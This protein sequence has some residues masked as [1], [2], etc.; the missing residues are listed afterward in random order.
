MMQYECFLAEITCVSLVFGSSTIK[1]LELYNYPIT[2][3]LSFFAYNCVL[4]ILCWGIHLYEGDGDKIQSALA[5]WTGQTTVPNVFIG[6]KHIG[7]C[8]GKNSL[9]I[10]L[11]NAYCL[12]RVYFSQLFSS[13]IPICIVAAV[14]EKHRRG[15][16]IPLLTEAGAIASNSAQL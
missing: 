15:Q 1:W 3:S 6:E 9:L 8:D 13:S 11:H 5:E 10:S 12:V 14:T 16:L 2:S 4:Q 7:G